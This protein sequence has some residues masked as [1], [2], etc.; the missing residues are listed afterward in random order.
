MSQHF[1][2]IVLLV[3]SL[4]GSGLALA[5]CSRASTPIPTPRPTATLQAGWK[6]LEGRNVSIALPESFE[7]GSLSGKD[8]ELL[9]EQMKNL[10]EDFA[11]AVQVME[12]NPDLYLLFAMDTAPTDSGVL[13]NLNIVSEKVLSLITPKTYMEV[14][15]KQ[16]PEQYDIQSQEELTINGRAAGRIIT[17]WSKMNI[18]QVLYVIKDNDTIYVATFTSS[19]ADFDTDLPLFEQSIQSLAIRSQ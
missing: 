14:V 19:P 12:Q 8:R 5:A 2:K 10:G 16:L 1:S 4:I 6:R 7:G 11:Q 17:E 15:R 18:K 13:A 3:L 9:I